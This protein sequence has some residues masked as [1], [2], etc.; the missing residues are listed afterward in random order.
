MTFSAVVTALLIL[1]T[2]LAAWHI[3][4][5]Y[6][7]DRAYGAHERGR[8]PDPDPMDLPTALAI[9]RELAS[10]VDRLQNG[11]P[12]RTALLLAEIVRA[13]RPEDELTMSRQMLD[14]LDEAAALVHDIGHPDRSEDGLA[15]IGNQHLTPA[16]VEQLAA[17]IA[18]HDLQSV[19]DIAV[20]SGWHRAAGTIAKDDGSILHLFAPDQKGDIL[21]PEGAFAVVE[22]DDDPPFETSSFSGYEP[23]DESPVGSSDSCPICGE[24]WV[25]KE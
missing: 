19:A 14:L 1:L 17:M 3:G 4:I 18:T 8:R 5:R 20:I 11:E 2:I 22:D 6:A 7:P 23:D 9:I 25:G 15:T 10:T 16:E 24:T 21:G 12:S 13:K